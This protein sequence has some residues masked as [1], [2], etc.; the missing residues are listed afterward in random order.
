MPVGSGGV[1][2]L[3]VGEPVF[4]TARELVQELSRRGF[5]EYTPE[6]VRQWVRQEPPLPIA[7]PGKRGQ[8]HRFDPDAAATWLQQRDQAEKAKG[9]TPPPAAEGGSWPPAESAGQP[10]AGAAPSDGFDPSKFRDPRNFKAY[11]DG[12]L[13]QLRADEME[14]RLIPAEE[15]EAA[16]RQLVFSVRSALLAM[17]AKL[18]TE[19]ANCDDYRARRDLL[20]REVDSV[21][22]DL[23]DASEVDHADA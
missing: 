1:R 17:P 21:L 22:R 9:W 14:R 12:R 18:A 23:A 20:Q 7:K 4:L 10:D 19:M 5:G 3:A 2:G 8:A 13:A 16:M 11:H 6:A 15:I